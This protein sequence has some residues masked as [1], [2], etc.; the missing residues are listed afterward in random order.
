MFW[1]KMTS[2]VLALVADMETCTW[3]SHAQQ[4]AVVD[5]RDEAQDTFGLLQLLGFQAQLPVAGRRHIGPVDHDL[6]ASPGQ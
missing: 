1:L 2:S 5:D 6:D 3:H 4:D